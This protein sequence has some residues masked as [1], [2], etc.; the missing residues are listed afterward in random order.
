MKRSAAARKE[1]DPAATRRRIVDAAI[2][3]ILRQGYAATTVDQVCTA[4]GVTKGAYFHHFGGKEAVALAAVEAW[5]DHG[6]ALYAEAWKNPKTDPL[7]QLHAM[8]DIMAGFTERPD[9][10]CTCVVGML[11]QEVAQ[12]HPA[13]R[14]E[15]A[16]QLERWTEN[17]ARLL[18]AAKRKHAP[19]AKFDPVAAAWFLNSLWQGSMLVGKTREAPEMVRANLKMARR[20]IDGLLAK[21]PPPSVS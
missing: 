14:A 8:L 6:T 17:I 12:S 19:R 11:S 10:V 20:F 7:K 15:C 4:S 16:R 5:G 1:R 13:L 3:L 21:T 18:A 9:Q 2:G